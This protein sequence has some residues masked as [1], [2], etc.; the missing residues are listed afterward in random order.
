MEDVELTKSFPAETFDEALEAWS[1]IG[2]AGK[3][4]VLSS[5]FGDV[6]FESD[7]GCWYL[8]TIEGTL[9]CHW[10]NRTSLDR[11]LASEDG[12]TR[13]L[14]DGIAMSA[15]RSGL[16]LGPGQ[17]YAFAPPPCLSGSFDVANL[18]VMDF[19]VAVDVTGQLHRQL[20]EM[21][22]GTQISGFTVDGQVPAAPQPRK[23]RWRRSS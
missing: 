21:P 15:E 7:D 23:R 5:L 17:V 20:R 9:E 12:Q 4:P 1:W 18:M 8:D 14:L 11:E 16:Y 3:T 2:L 13:F 19:V 10:G 22:A 6:F